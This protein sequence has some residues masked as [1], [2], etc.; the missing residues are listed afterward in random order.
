MKKVILALNNILRI[1]KNIRLRKYG[2]L[3]GKNLIILSDKQFSKVNAP[4]PS[5]L[6]VSAVHHFLIKEG[7]RMKTSLVIETGEA[8]E[9][10]H[11][12]VLSGF[13]AE[14]INPYLAFETIR[15]FVPDSEVKISEENFIK[16]ANKAQLSIGIVDLLGTILDT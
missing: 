2:I 9:L 10:H 13:G 14:A 7:L 8:R 1:V 15:S 12:A 6:A 3:E 4:I 5:L 16:A 11:F